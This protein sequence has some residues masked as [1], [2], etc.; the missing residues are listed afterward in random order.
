MQQFKTMELDYDV[1][2]SRYG[3]VASVRV[4]SIVKFRN[5]SVNVN[6]VLLANGHH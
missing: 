2:E 1:K 5:G 6:G 3:K 4:L